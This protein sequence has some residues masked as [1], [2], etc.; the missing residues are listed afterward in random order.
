M[1]EA[2]HTKSNNKLLYIIY[3]IITILL[4]SLIIH[5]TNTH[6]N[7]I[8]FSATVEPSLN[9]TIP[10]NLVS[11]NLN[12]ANS[13]FSSQDLTVSVGTNNTTGYTLTMTAEG[14]DLTRTEALSGS[15]PTIST[16]ASEVAES[17]F[18]PNRW[19]Y[20][21]SDNTTNT[22]YQ[23]FTTN[24]PF[25]ESS[26][27][28]NN[29]S[30][31]IT[32]GAKVDTEQVP[33][34]YELSLTFTA[35]AKAPLPHIQNYDSVLCTS[36]PSL[37]YDVRDGNAYTIQ[38]LADGKCWMT[39]NLNLV[40]GTRLESTNSDVPDGYTLFNPYYTLPDSLTIT[41]GTSVNGFNSDT[42]A[43]VFN[44]GNI[45]TSQSDC[46]S[47]KPCNSYYSWLA[48]TA[49]GKDNNGNDVTA[50]G[51]NAAYSICPKGW[52]LPTSTT[53]NANAQSNNNWK[54][55]DWYALATA[56]GADLESNYYQSSN[57]FYNNAGPGTTPNFLPA[58]YYSSGSFYYG[59]FGGFY[60]S[61]ASRSSADAYF[62]SFD[63]SNVNSASN[64]GRRRGY[65]VRCVLDEPPTMQEQ[66]ADTL[67]ALLPNEGDSTTLRDA[68]DNQTYTV[69]NI[70]GNYWMTQNLRFDISTYSMNTD[71]SNMAWSAQPD[72]TTWASDYATPRIYKRGDS[73]TSADRQTYGIHYNYC[74]ASAGTNCQSSDATNSG[75]TQN[76]CPKGW[77]L[78]TQTQVGSIGTGNSTYVSTFAPV[79]GFI[80]YANGT[81]YP[82]NYGYWWSATASDAI[83]QYSLGY[84]RTN[85]SRNLGDKR[86]GLYVRC[87]L[88]PE[89][90]MQSITS[91][92]LA[93]AMP[94]DGDS[95]TL[96]DVRDGNTYQVT[97][98][99][100]NYWMTENLRYLG[101][102]GS[103]SNS[104]TIKTATTNINV[105]K[106][107]SYGDLTSGNDYSEARIH[108]PNSTNDSSALAILTPE[109]I[110]VWYNYAAASAGTI[111]GNSNSTEASYDLCPKNWHLPA[112]NSSAAGGIDSITSYKD[113]FSPVYG[114]RYDGGSLY[115]AATYG[116]WWSATANNS[117]YRYYL[118]Y[119][120]GSLS[121]S[122]G[123]YRG[124]GYYVRC[125]RTT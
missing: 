46:T 12:P 27:A 63:S 97:K 83:R 125:V 22:N 61:S 80:D 36:S 37:V 65:S 96:K 118:Y 109:Q 76:I 82:A 123:G 113:A 43:F 98:I 85:L 64:N 9:V 31:T 99:N 40:G 86:G 53:S 114:G 21:F 32:F 33:G 70:N 8:E 7:S 34:T 84:N 59:G 48:A 115:S 25:N 44:T 67:A 119:D 120:S 103:A 1:K 92:E 18:T 58:G 15:Y 20:R 39:S 66:T 81:L 117:P 45:T 68:R 122:S 69:A 6:A 14:T 24:L 91:A 90:T 49:G 73:A 26:E 111:T 79:T 4:F 108:I 5:S 88:T 110:G 104:M 38:R 75:T 74:A 56:Y 101:D 93:T 3:S 19:G 50:D 11:L 95:T 57:T 29:D 94:N 106:T 102:T 51:Y 35:V 54:T 78:P 71:T 16:L 112:G 13:A 42:E 23:P 17:S 41:S 77:T 107:L 30:R 10:T 116:Y 62:L 124:Y 72:S 121:T 105:D 2:I 52:K 60:W 55:G 28:V 87:I 100:G 89:P 47:S